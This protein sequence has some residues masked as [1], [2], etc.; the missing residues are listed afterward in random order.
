MKLKYIQ[1]KKELGILYDWNFIVK[2]FKKIVPVEW[3]GNINDIPFNKADYFVENSERSIGKTTKWLLLGMIMNKYYGTHIQYVRQILDMIMPKNMKLFRTILD[4]GYID[5]ITEG[6]YNSVKY[7]SRAYYYYNTE[8]DTIASEPFCDCLSID[9]NDKYVSSYNAPTGD[10]IIFDEFISRKYYHQNEFVD[11]EDLVKTIIRDR[12]SP[13]IVMLAN[14]IDIYNEY[15]KELEIYD[16]V[17][18]MHMGQSEI[19]TTEMGTRIYFAL[20][21]GKNTDNKKRHNLQYFGF[22]NPRL[23]S[24]RGGDWAIKSYPH[25]PKFLKNNRPQTLINNRYIAYNN[26]LLHI[27][28]VNNN[29]V[30]CAFI[31]ESTKIYPDSVVYTNTTPH[32]RNERYGYGYTNTDRFIWTLKNRNLFFYANNTVGEKLRNYIRIITQNER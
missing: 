31:Y 23:N 3:H 13:I 27:E 7:I 11:F 14:T 15:Y 16:Y 29:S 17:Q 4:Y 30:P 2:E 10:I 28:I 20:L 5:K 24:I 8:T 22:K 12:Q 9:N 18:T 21:T 25:I 6:E 32:T 1:N 19:I 26:I